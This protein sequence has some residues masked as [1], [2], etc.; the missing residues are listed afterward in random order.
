MPKHLFVSA[1]RGWAPLIVI[2][3]RNALPRVSECNSHCKGGIHGPGREGGDPH[4]PPMKGMW[5][6]PRDRRGGSILM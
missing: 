5:G 3:G 2:Q 1:F 6:P 4:G